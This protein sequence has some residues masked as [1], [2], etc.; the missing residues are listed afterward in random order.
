M[1]LGGTES[2]AEHPATMTHADVEPEDRQRQ[3]IT[4]SLIRLSIGVEHYEDLVAD[5]EQALEA[6][7][8]PAARREPE[9]AQV[10]K[11]QAAP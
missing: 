1:S 10:S 11:A 8:A 4:P 2:L 7:G 3:G 6:V 5:I 9:A